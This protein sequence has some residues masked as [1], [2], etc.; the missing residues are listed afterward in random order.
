MQ[1]PK[2]NKLSGSFSERQHASSLNTLEQ[3]E[4]NKGN[5][6]TLPRTSGSPKVDDQVTA[7]HVDSI[8]KVEEK[9]LEAAEESL[10]RAQLGKE[11]ALEPV[12]DLNPLPVGESSI[13]RE[14]QHN[15]LPEKDSQCK[16]QNGNKTQA[17][18]NNCNKHTSKTKH[19]SLKPEGH[20]GRREKSKCS[21]DARFEGERIPHL[22]KQRRYQKEDTEEERTSK[23][24]EDYVL[25]KLFKKSGNSFCV[26]FC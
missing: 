15:L 25:E 5:P 21:R 16:E 7:A 22:M 20:K 9:L 10:Y 6:E 4:N 3:A 13:G 23:K 11:E 2:C 17:Y 12:G 19:H 24:N 14:G 26:S 8:T 1:M 18:F